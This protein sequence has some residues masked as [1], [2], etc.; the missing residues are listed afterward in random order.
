MIYKKMAIKPHKDEY[1]YIMR[2]LSRSSER[3]IDLII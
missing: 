1:L 2:C 3:A